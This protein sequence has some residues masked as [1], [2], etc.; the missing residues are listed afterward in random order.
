MMVYLSGPIADCTDEEAGAWRDYATQR[1][2]ADKVFDPFKQRDFRKNSEGN[3]TLIVEGDKADILA[4]TLVLANCWKTA[5][6][7]CMEIM[8][9]YDHNIPVVIVVPPNKT[10]SPW[11]VY[12]GS[13]IPSLDEAI[14][15][16][17]HVW[18]P[19]WRT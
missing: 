1:F 9:A 15:E 6:G 3:E 4:S 5:T 19:Q 12:H 18:G 11:L 10:P 8:F 2:G 17:L 13:I 14:E 7:T 16:I